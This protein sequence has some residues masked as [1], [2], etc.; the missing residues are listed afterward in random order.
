MSL[1]N[2]DKINKLSFP[3]EDE[4]MI[5]NVERIRRDYGEDY[6]GIIIIKP[7]VSLE[8]TKYLKELVY[9]LLNIQELYV[10]SEKEKR[11]D[12]KDVTQIYQ[13]IYQEKPLNS[14]DMDYKNNLL[15]Y[16]I[17]G[18]STA[19]L[20]FGENARISSEEIKLKIRTMF[21]N[22]F[23]TKYLRNFVHVPD[24]DEFTTTFSVVWR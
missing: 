22:D 24:K 4:F 11:L 23:E 10:L 6:L 7:Q 1:E 17:S 3:Q 15:D 13:R 9:E 20:I 8:E 12:T 21:G 2:I 18:E 5:S 16:M 19:L 14:D